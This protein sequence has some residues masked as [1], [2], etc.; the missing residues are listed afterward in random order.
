MCER[1]GHREPL[2]QVQKT[3]F[4]PADIDRER[5]TGERGVVTVQRLYQ[6]VLMY[7]MRGIISVLK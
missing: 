2:A 1:A 7:V 5:D 4:Y 6:L 3:G